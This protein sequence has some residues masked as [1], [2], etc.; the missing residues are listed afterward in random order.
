MR[1]SKINLDNYSYE[2]LEDI[3][4][5]A[6]ADLNEMELK[7]YKK[8]KYVNWI[9]KKNGKEIPYNFKSKTK[10]KQEE[11]KEFVVPKI[12]KRVVS[13]WKVKTDALKMPMWVN[14]PN[15][16]KEEEIIGSQ[17][18]VKCRG[19]ISPLKIQK[20]MITNQ[21][22]IIVEEEKYTL[23]WQ[24]AWWIRHYAPTSPLGTQELKERVEK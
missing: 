5:K 18:L 19:K 3:M 4:T 14:P 1:K 24:Q 10:N 12:E 22:I 20:D 6:I 17:C 21:P 11:K 7:V 16:I 9:A 2:E 23:N 13:S 15:K 8:I